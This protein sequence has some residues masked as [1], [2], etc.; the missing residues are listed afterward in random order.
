MKTVLIVDDDSINLFLAKK[1]LDKEYCVLTAS[2]GQEA[3]CILKENKTDLILLDISM[4]VMDGR[5]TMKRIREFPFLSKIPIIFLTADYN[6]ETEA[7]CLNDGAEDFIAKPFVPKVM[8]SRVSRILELNDLRNDLED[9]LE[10][11]A[12]Q[13]EL[14]TLESI[15]AIANTIEAK[16]LYTSGHSQRVAKCSVA[17]AQALG[18]SDE[19]I[20]TLNYMA[21]LHDIG[22]IAIP[23]A[24]LNKTERLTDEEFDIIKTHPLAGYEILK[25]I[26]TIDN[27]S[28]GA[29]YHHER[30][31][32][33]GYPLGLKGENIPFMARIIA[34]ADAYDAMT[35]DRAYRRAMDKEVVYSE[36]I[37]GSGKQFDPDILKCFIGMLDNGFAI[38]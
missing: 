25:N 11:K 29:L 17:I 22:K 24:V 9:R 21:L 28:D 10:E 2:S 18:M 26:K 16:D 4:P 3:I 8:Q 13:V 12:R 27:L 35:S 1:T 38:K 30:Y 23:D 14:V 33:S 32:G 6:P 20:K 34:V 36:L 15:M 37:N 19:D 31:N 7:Q 5:E